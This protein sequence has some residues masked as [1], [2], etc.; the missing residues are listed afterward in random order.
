M[1][2]VPQRSPTAGAVRKTLSSSNLLLWTLI[3]I[4]KKSMVTFDDIKARA[5]EYDLPIL[6]AYQS[7]SSQPDHPKFRTV[8]L[9]DIAIP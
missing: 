5:E 1:R 6:F 2:F 8:F 3:M 4:N 9:N 7:M